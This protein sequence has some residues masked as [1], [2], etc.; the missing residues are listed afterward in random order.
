MSN[1]TV[2]NPVQ[3]QQAQQQ[4][5]NP[6]GSEGTTGRVF[7]QD[8]VNQIVRDRLARARGKEPDALTARENNLAARESRLLCREWVADK[9]DTCPA[10]LLDVLDT[11][12]FDA[13]KENAEKIVEMFKNQPNAEERPR[14]IKVGASTAPVGLQGLTGRDRIAEMFRPPKG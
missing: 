10:G 9:R 3:D 11:S 8:E 2:N 12:N 4:D 13:F 1:E 7:T 14:G 5:A 6:A